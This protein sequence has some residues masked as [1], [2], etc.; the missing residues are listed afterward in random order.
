MTL[1]AGVQWQEAYDFAFSRQRDI[2]GGLSLGGSVGA[3]GGWLQGGGHS[4][5]AAKYGLG[6]CHARHS[7]MAGDLTKTY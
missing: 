2:V 3:A 7:I 6:H 1:G 4:I 5:L